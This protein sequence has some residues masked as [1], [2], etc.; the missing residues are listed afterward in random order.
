MERQEDVLEPE[1]ARVI[2][3]GDSLPANSDKKE[4]EVLL[5][6]EVDNIWSL[7]FAW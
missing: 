2:E 1:N 7:L 6:N 3:V 5:V 4:L